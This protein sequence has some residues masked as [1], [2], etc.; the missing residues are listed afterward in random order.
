MAR[1][2]AKRQYRESFPQPGGNPRLKIPDSPF[3]RYKI[4]TFLRGKPSKVE[5]DIVKLEETLSKTE[6][7]RSK[8]LVLMLK[9]REAFIEEVDSVIL[10][11]KFV[12]TN[13]NTFINIATHPTAKELEESRMCYGGKMTEEQ[14][15]KAE[16]MLKDFLLLIE[17]HIADILATIQLANIPDYSDFIKKE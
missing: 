15:T 17:Q 7:A 3:M 2:G 12:A 4:A 1:D 13:V 14:A 8:Y 16:L 5:A 9:I 11:G 6:S 10:T